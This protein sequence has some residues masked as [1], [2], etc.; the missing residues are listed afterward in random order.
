MEILLDFFEHFNIL[1]IL[2][3]FFEYLNTWL[4]FVHTDERWV[5]NVNKDET[6]SLHL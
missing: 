4:R 2:L 3:D 6:T 1:I 5:E